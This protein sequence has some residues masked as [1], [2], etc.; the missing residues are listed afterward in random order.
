M[1]KV[2]ILTLRPK[3]PEWTPSLIVLLCKSVQSVIVRRHA[4]YPGCHRAFVRCR[5]GVL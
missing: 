5:V 1:E 2:E 4:G 3:Y